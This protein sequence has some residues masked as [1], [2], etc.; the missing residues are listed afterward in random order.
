MILCWGEGHGSAIHDHAD[1]HCFMKMLDGELSE[2]RYAWPDDRQ[3]GA[4]DDPTSAA[5]EPLS[6][7]AEMHR[8][9]EDEENEYCSSE[10]VELS[11]SSMYRNEVI[12]INGEFERMM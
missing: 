8:S 7:I 2:V 9:E 6:S 10:L 4:T 3:Q 5:G 12:Y 1:S 11:R